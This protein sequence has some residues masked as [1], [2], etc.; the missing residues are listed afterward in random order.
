VGCEDLG[1]SGELDLAERCV[2]TPALVGVRV[3]LARGVGAVACRS[4][5]DGRGT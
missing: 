1:R 4:H 3:V 5:Y 2:E